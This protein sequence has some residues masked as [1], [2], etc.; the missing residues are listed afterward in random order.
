M[1][2]NLKNYSL[3]TG[4]GTQLGF[5]YDRVNALTGRRKEDYLVRVPNSPLAGLVDYSLGVNLDSAK[6][7]TLMAETKI[8]VIDYNGSV[9]INLMTTDAYNMIRRPDMSV[10]KMLSLAE[11][12]NVLAGGVLPNAS[13]SREYTKNWLIHSTVYS[14]HVNL[15]KLLS[16]YL[17]V[18]ESNMVQIQ[19]AKPAAFNQAYPRIYSFDSNITDTILYSD[20]VALKS[21]AAIAIQAQAVLLSEFWALSFRNAWEELV[22][23]GNNHRKVNE[24]YMRMTGPEK[25]VEPLQTL[26]LI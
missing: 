25:L 10:L 2:N 14:E 9:T 4:T 7:H 22:Q 12:V 19:T 11:A 23:L 21:L 6:T 18:T 5:E 15:A 3:N 17:K 8:Y 16:S 24:L 20:G 13:T 1:H 26:G